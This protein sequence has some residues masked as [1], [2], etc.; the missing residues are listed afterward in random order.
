MII[1][2]KSFE[3]TFHF[4]IFPPACRLYIDAQSGEGAGVRRREFVFFIALFTPSSPF[5]STFVRQFYIY[6]NIQYIFNFPFSLSLCS[7]KVS[8]HILCTFE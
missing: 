2:R 4:F 1:K 6:Q 8:L 5:C 3:N 7:T